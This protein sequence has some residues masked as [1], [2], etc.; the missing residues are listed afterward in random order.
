MDMRLR[1]HLILAGGEGP[2]T[3]RRLDGRMKRVPYRFVSRCFSPGARDVDPP[4]GVMH[5]DLGVVRPT[6]GPVVAG[7]DGLFGRY[8]LLLFQEPMPL[9]PTERKAR[10]VLPLTLRGAA[11]LGARRKKSKGSRMKQPV[12]SYA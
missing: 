8:D 2:V 7:A 1:A 6:R 4:S 12:S 5:K 11:H 9:L 10:E 3:G